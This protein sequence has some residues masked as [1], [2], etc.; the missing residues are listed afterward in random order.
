[1]QGTAGR[2]YRRQRRLLQCQ[3]SVRQSLRP[4]H[5]V[6]GRLRGLRACR[7]R[8]PPPPLLLPADSTSSARSCTA[9]LG[10]SAQ[11]SPAAA[12]ACAAA[13]A[14]PSGRPTRRAPAPAATRQPAARTSPG[15]SGPRPP[16]RIPVSGTAGQGSGSRPAVN[17]Q[18]SHGYGQQACCEQALG[19][20]RLAA[21]HEPTATSQ[22]LPAQA[23]RR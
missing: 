8:R 11:P 20:H 21:A 16:P 2:P 13:T 5:A 1:M 14:R 6:L 9:G 22:P 3:R 17:S 18:P 12:A 23:A 15:R 19:S 7:R 10:A 4:H